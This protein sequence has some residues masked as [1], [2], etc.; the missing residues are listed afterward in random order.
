MIL[1][2][3]EKSCEMT[4]VKFTNFSAD[5]WKKLP[6]T[7]DRKSLQ[8]RS[9]L[10]LGQLF[11]AYSESSDLALSFLALKF[12]PPWKTLGDTGPQSWAKFDQK[13]PK[14]QN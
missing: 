13:W 2:K 5:F 11:G 8:N 3:F 1:R 4:P 10:P 6:S 12:L 9:K 7:P 14:I